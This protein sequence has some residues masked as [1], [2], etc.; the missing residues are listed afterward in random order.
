MKTMKIKSLIASALAVLC[1]GSVASIPVFAAE[2]NDNDGTQTSVILQEGLKNGLKNGTKAGIKN[3][4]K[5]GAK[6]G[7]KNGL[8]DGIKAGLKNG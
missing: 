1:I 3:G 5:D 4:L 2:T 6:A 7:L 8:K